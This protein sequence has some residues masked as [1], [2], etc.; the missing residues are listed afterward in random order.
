MYPQKIMQPFKIA[1]WIVAWIRR[2]AKSK[3]TVKRLDRLWRKA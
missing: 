3:A 1:S 2:K